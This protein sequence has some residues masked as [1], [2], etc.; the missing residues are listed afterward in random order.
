MLYILIIF[1]LIS[2]YSWFFCNVFNYWHLKTRISNGTGWYDYNLIILVMFTI[3][4]CIFFHTTKLFVSDWQFNRLSYLILSSYVF[5]LYKS[6]WDIFNHIISHCCGIF[7]IDIYI[8]ICMY[9]WF[10]IVTYA[11]KDRLIN[12]IKSSLNVVLF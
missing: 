5:L 2:N 12:I 3:P 9:Q 8:F 10:H 6:V 1:F 11:I 7:Y 4:I